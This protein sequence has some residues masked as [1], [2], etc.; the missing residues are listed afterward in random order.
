MCESVTESV[1]CEHVCKGAEVTVCVSECVCQ[2]W[3]LTVY[4]YHCLCE[5]WCVG[6]AS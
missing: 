2:F 1:P 4:A 3:G 5:S 6:L